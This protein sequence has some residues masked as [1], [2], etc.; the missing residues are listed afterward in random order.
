MPTHRTIETPRYSY[1]RLT[2]PNLTVYTAAQC[3][4]CDEAK[5]TLDRLAPELGLDV[6]YIDIAGNPELEATWREQLPA[7]VLD[8]RKVF[9]YRVDEE[10]LRRRVRRPRPTARPVR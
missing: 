6:T 7:G 2:M 1:N 3:S 8:G 4:L 5:L 9:K 10:L